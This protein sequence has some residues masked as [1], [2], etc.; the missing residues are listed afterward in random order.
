METGARILPATG[1]KVGTGMFENKREAGHC[2]HVIPALWELRRE[3][4][5]FNLTTVSKA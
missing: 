4:F 1:W 3:D 2:G 5:H